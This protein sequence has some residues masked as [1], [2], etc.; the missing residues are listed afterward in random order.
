[1]LVSD[2]SAQLWGIVMGIDGWTSVG[3]GLA[4]NDVDHRWESKRDSTNQSTHQSNFLQ[5]PLH[6]A[7]KI[8]IIEAYI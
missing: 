3:N 1:M 5:E 6:I 4:Q 7:E 8:Q 2:I